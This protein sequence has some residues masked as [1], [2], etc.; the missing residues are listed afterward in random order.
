MRKGREETGLVEVSP[1]TEDGAREVKG[2][3][4]GACGGAP[5]DGGRELGEVEWAA[6]RRGRGGGRWGK[7][8]REAPARKEEHSVQL[9]S[10]CDPYDVDVVDPHMEERGRTKC[11]DWRAYIGVRDDLD[12]EDVGY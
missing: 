9:D 1:E 5:G 8:R 3:R 12:T 4:E 11:D 6:G 7:K 2:G 10:L